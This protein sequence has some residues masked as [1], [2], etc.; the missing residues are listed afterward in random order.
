MLLVMLPPW[1]VRGS[2][3]DHHWS[4]LHCTLDPTL[5]GID[6]SKLTPIDGSKLTPNDDFTGT[7]TGDWMQAGTGDPKETGYDNPNVVGTDDPRE[8]VLSSSS[9]ENSSK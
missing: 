9:G 6:G 8:A 7:G 4:T 5:T 2:L 3:E 1:G